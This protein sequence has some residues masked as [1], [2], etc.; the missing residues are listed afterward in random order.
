MDT[1]T[2]R[3]IAEALRDK[4]I[5]DIVSITIQTNEK[6]LIEDIV[7]LKVTPKSGPWIKLL[8]N[9]FGEKIFMEFFYP[10]EIDLPFEASEDDI[11]S[12]LN[13]QLQGHLAV[14][15]TL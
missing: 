13:E 6:G 10:N 5:R 2:L 7:H 15:I 3:R 11:Y 8:N 4:N 9:I 1:N 14:A 12:K